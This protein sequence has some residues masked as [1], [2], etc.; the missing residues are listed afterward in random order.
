MS[1]RPFS[2]PSGGRLCSACLFLLVFSFFLLRGA[3]P[4]DLAEIQ[5]ALEREFG[6][7]VEVDP[8]DPYAEFKP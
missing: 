6:Q 1:F 2:F 5:A 3:D 8:Y 7:P 4:A